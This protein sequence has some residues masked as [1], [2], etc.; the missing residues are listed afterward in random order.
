MASWF[1]DSDLQ[2]RWPRR[3]ADLKEQWKKK[4][5]S[6]S[7]K[8]HYVGRKRNTGRVHNSG[9][10][11]VFERSLHETSEKKEIAKKK[12]LEAGIFLVWTFFFTLS[13]ADVQCFSVKTGKYTAYIY[14][15][16]Q[17]QYFRL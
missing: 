16:G 7:P 17:C 3:T 5:S 4:L 8:P 6:K 10:G 9:Q 13:P 12:Y 15:R 2:A 1:T 14:A 11:N